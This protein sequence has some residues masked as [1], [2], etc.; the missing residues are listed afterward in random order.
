M[1]KIEKIGGVTLDYTFYNGSD[2]YSD[3]DEVEEFILE[4]FKNDKDIFKVLNED[5]R[6]PV[7]C[8]LSPQRANITEPM[9]IEKEDE[10]LEIGSGFGAITAPLAKKAKHVDGIDLSGRRSL[11]NAYRNKQQDNITIFIGN[12]ENIELEKKY[13][14]VVAVGVLEYAQYYVHGLNPFDLFLK[15]VNVLLK[16]HGKLYVAIENRLGMKYF[17]GANEDHLCIPYVGIEGY[18][19]DTVKN[20]ARTFTRSELDRLIKNA[21]FVSAYFYYP[22][23][24][25]KLPTVIFSDDYLPSDVDS[26]PP[27]F[28]YDMPRVSC[29]NE[30]N[31]MHSL[32]GTE[33]FKTFANSFLVEAITA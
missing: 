15:K 12:F 25:Y 9:S 20:R 24:D 1:K 30:G 27:L 11:A 5:S 22:L 2:C 7:L 18:R 31:A 10:V 21:G 23:P 3:G 4:V 19:E 17:S 6:W 32:L 29:F 26:L 8:H 28:I 16:P 14:V 33:E 13:D